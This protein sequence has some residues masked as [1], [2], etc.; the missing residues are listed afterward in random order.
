VVGG[1]VTGGDVTGGDVAG[2]AVTGGAVTGGGVT[3]AGVGGATVP[4]D[5]IPGVVEWFAAA[6]VVED[7]EGGGGA[8]DDVE[9]AV[10][11]D[12][13]AGTTNHSLATPC[14]MVSPAFLSPLKR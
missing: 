4:P 9:G 3:E 1:E 10:A 14:P 8:V 2:G 12:A 11:A 7:V 13:D 6:G 5:D